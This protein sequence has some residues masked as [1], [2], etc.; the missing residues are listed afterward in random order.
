MAS[1]GTTYVEVVDGT[2]LVANVRLYCVAFFHQLAE[3][4]HAYNNK[5][6][7]PRL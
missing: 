3:A 7:T 5:D 2:S 1:E 6:E 4:N